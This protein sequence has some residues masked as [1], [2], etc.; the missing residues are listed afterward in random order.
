ML[1]QTTQN[2][3]YPPGLCYIIQTRCITIVTARQSPADDSKNNKQVKVYFYKLQ[4]HQNG[5][6]SYPDVKVSVFYEHGYNL[7]LLINGGKGM[8]FL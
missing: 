3:Y 5:N 4:V 8:D 2:K 1:Q 6:V 7:L